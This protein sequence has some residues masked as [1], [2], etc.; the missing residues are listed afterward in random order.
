MRLLELRAYAEFEKKRT[1]FSLDEP[2]THTQHSRACAVLIVSFAT[3]Q[4]AHDR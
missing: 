4:T 3:P 2:I 1:Q